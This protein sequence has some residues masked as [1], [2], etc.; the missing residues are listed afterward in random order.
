MQ[1]GHICNAVCIVYLSSSGAINDY[2]QSAKEID[3]YFKSQL[4]V[5]DPGRSAVDGIRIHNLLI[6]D[7]WFTSRTPL[8]FANFKGLS[9]DGIKP[10]E[11]SFPFV[12]IS[13]SHVFIQHSCLAMRLVRNCC[14]E[15]A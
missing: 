7:A 6:D 13:K 10:I 15:R 5:E 8:L 9:G 12:N 11:E 2:S 1:D 14:S 4:Y 3:T